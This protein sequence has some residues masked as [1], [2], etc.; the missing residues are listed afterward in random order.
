MRSQ[1]T[2]SD[3]FIQAAPTGTASIS[4]GLSGTVKASPAKKNRSASR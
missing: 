1:S 3:I 4:T 2:A